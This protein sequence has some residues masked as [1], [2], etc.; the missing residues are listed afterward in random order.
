MILLPF[1]LG[2]A[3]QGNLLAFTRQRFKWLR[4]VSLALVL[5]PIAGAVCEAFRHYMLWRLAVVIWV[6]S[7]LL[8][9]VGW[10]AA[11]GLEVKHRE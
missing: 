8:Y 2:L 7:A 4:F 3:I 11:W 9:L 5:I 10:G 6:A 1:F